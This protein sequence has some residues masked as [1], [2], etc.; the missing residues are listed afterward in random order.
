MQPID[1]LMTKKKSVQ[2]RARILDAA[3]RILAEHGYS[4]A[5]L[6]D[7]ADAAG[8]KAGSLYY[9]FDSRE[10]LVEEVLSIA[11][12]RVT[13]AV[14][15]AVRDLPKDSTYR[16]K[17]TAALQTNL[18]LALEY[19]VY[20]AA[21]LRSATQLPPLLRQRQL[22]QQRNYGR[23]W[24]KLLGE[25]KAAGEIDPSFDLSVLRMLILGAINW[26]V[27]WYKHNGALSAAEIAVQ[28]SHLVFDG[29][30]CRPAA[31]RTTAT[32]VPA[33]PRSATRRASRTRKTAAEVTS[34]A[35]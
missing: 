13:T 33:T 5:R 34:T 4:G 35:G 32:I 10:Q 8:T 29:V 7:I 26:S 11:L 22:S 27:E 30:G 31:G 6:E 23:Y 18:R 9:Y 19:D 15:Q 28:L 21:S 24:R 17:I 25:A 3:A 20:T 12:Q 14:R 1:M 2:T 16:D